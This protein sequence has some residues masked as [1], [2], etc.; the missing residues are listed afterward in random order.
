MSETCETILRELSRVLANH[1]GGGSEWFKRIGDN[2]YIDPKAVAAELQRRKT[3]AQITKRALVR[4][5]Q[6]L[7]AHQ[8]KETPHE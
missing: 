7:D 2:F 8:P 5:N 3:D 4:A 6:K 1:L